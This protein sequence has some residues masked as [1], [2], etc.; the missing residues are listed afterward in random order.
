[1][2]PQPNNFPPSP[3]RDSEGSAEGVMEKKTSAFTRAMLK[4]R[5]LEYFQRGEEMPELLFM[6]KSGHQ[7]DYSKFSK[8]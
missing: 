2:I 1:M 6:E 8:A 3:F 5:Q 4:R 7:I